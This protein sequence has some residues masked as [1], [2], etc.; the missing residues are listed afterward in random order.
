MRGARDLSKPLKRPDIK[1]PKMLNSGYEN[2]G[3]LVLVILS[4]VLIVLF[5]V[6]GH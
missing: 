4:G 2:D 1:Q 3:C 6:L 5:L